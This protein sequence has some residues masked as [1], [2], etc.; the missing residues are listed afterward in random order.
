MNHT[1]GEFE[2][3]E[4]C[5]YSQ[6]CTMRG[7]FLFC[8]TCS[9]RVPVPAYL[10]SQALGSTGPDTLTAWVGARL[11]ITCLGAAP[12]SDAQPGKCNRSR[13]YLARPRRG[14]FRSPLLCERSPASRS[15]GEGQ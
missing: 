13:E 15:S 4:D 11:S 12:E 14:T 9:V 10:S 5:V 3:L 6:T 1:L 8:R 2:E 7:V